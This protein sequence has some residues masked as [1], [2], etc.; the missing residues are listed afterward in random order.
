MSGRKPLWIALAAVPLIFLLGG[1]LA[2]RQMAHQFIEYSRPFHAFTCAGAI[3]RSGGDPYRVEPLLSCEHEASVPAAVQEPAGVAEP[4]PLPGY[5]LAFFSLF[6][7]LPYETAAL[8]WA[9]ILIEALVIAT[10]ALARM[11]SIPWYAIA[12]AMLPNAGIANVTQGELTPLCIAAV[13]LSAL[14]LSRGLYTGAAVAVCLAMIEPHLGLAAFIGLFVFAPK[15]RWTLAVCGGLLALVSLATLGVG[16]NIEYVLGALPAQA[17]SE[18][19]ASDQFSLAWVLHA[20]GVSPEASLIAGSL[21]YPIAL[22]AGL[23]LA[24]RWA[25]DLSSPELFVLVPAAAVLIGGIYIHDIQM[26]AALPAA[27]VI[28][29]RIAGRRV[30][31]FAAVAL[32]AIPWGALEGFHLEARLSLAIVLLFALDRGMLQSTANRIAFGAAGTLAVLLVSLHPAAPSFYAAP[33]AVTE[34]SAFAATS[35]QRYIEA[36]AR[37]ATLSDAG[38]KGM[39]WLGFIASA[40]AAGGSR[41]ASARLA[42]AQHARLEGNEPSQAVS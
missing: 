22:A 15:A 37:P 35:W 16:G 33:P 41:S 25:Q 23:W 9:A 39:V 5:A 32:I 3:A 13:S 31:A 40:F 20:L 6:R 4:A 10:W 30:A 11:T 17:R 34:L 36:Y 29:D 12:A 27:L 18:L 7:A 42:A 14:L 21:S 8:I 26:V 1:M 2:P 24:R 38:R 28:A 19:F